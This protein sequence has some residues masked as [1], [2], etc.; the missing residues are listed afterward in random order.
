MSQPFE[1]LSMQETDATSTMSAFVPVLILSL[2][3]AAWFSF[4]A[5]QLRNE[6]DAMRELMTNQDKQMQESKKLRDSLDAIARG[7]AQLADAGNPNAR[8]VIDELKKRGVTVNPNPPAA[9][10]ESSTPAAPMPAK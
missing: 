5:A 4:Q 6:R 2:V 1:R 10:G 8:L 7:T 3:L 9:S